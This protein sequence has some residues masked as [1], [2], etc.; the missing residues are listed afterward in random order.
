MD[1]MTPS[2]SL[3]LA[4]TTIAA[5]ARGPFVWGSRQPTAKG[6]SYF[7]LIF[8]RRVSSLLRALG[9]YYA[10]YL[11]DGGT[12][13]P[14]MFMMPFESGDLTKST[15]MRIM[16]RH[17]NS[18][19]RPRGNETVEF[20]FN[21]MRR[22]KKANLGATF[23][24]CC[25]RSSNWSRLSLEDGSRLVRSCMKPMAALWVSLRDKQTS[26]LLPTAEV[27]SF[28]PDESSPLFVFGSGRGR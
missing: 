7:S 13:P 18:R 22:R 27:R 21:R 1:C 2:S 25:D 5:F 11:I 28:E 26:Q 23:S 6:L 4:R 9:Y 20:P 19:T 16:T 14:G 10:A 3:F 8:L 15:S 24:A 17:G 12:P